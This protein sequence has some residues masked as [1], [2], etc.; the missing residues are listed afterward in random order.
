MRD[1]LI[2]LGIIF[3]VIVGALATF[4][5]YAAYAGGKLDAS[6]KAYVDE[7]VPVILT[8]WSKDELIKRASPLLRA[9]ASDEEIAKLFATLSG[10]LGAF[11]SYEGA[12]GDSNVTWTTQDGKLTTAAYVANAT[13]QNGKAEIRIKLIQNNG[14]WQYLG[15]HVEMGL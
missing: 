3:L 6:S 2:I 5:G 9:K 12:K 14:V 11:K 8:N 13:F 7:T 4:I 1:I 15:F 10:K